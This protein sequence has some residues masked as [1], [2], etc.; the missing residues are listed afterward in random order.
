MIK[1]IIR[2]DTDQIVEIGECHLGVE[3]NMDR[4]I[5]ESCNILTL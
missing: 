1:V 2:I 3:L 4:I 5:E